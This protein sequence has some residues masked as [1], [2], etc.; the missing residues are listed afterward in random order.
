MSEHKAMGLPGLLRADLEAERAALFNAFREGGADA[1]LV[2]DT[3]IK[4]CSIDVDAADADRILDINPDTLVTLALRHGDASLLDVLLVH[5]TL[6]KSIDQHSAGAALLSEAVR[7]GASRPLLL[8][9]W[10]LCQSAGGQD[11][12]GRSPLGWALDRAVADGNLS[13]ARFLLERGADPDEPAVHEM[14]ARDLARTASG[15]GAES[16]RQLLESPLGLLSAAHNERALEFDQDLVEALAAGNIA[17]AHEAAAKGG[18]LRWGAWG[19]AQEPAAFEAGDA[20]AEAREILRRALATGSVEIAR[21]F[22]LESPMRRSELFFEALMSKCHEPAVFELAAA[23]MR[24]SGFASPSGSTLLHEAVQRKRMP[25]IEALLRRGADPYAQDDFGQTPA[26][27]AR[28]GADRRVMAVLGMNGPDDSADDIESGRFAGLEDDGTV[29]VVVFGPQS[30]GAFERRLASVDAEK[31]RVCERTLARMKQNDGERFGAPPPRTEAIKSLAND[32]PTFGEMIDMIAARA[33]TT[34]KAA[35]K[36]GQPRCF[37]LP[38][39]LLVG[40][41]GMGKTHVLKQLADVLETSFHMIQMGATSAGFVLAGMDSGWGGAKPGKIFEVLADGPY[42]NPIIA[43]DEID[44]ISRDDRY[45]VS[46]PLF[47]LLERGSAKEWSDEFVDAPM[48]ASHINFVATANSTELMDPAILSRFDVFHIPEPDDEEA[49]RIARSVYRAVLAREGWG[50]LFDPELEDA[51]LARLAS[52]TPR[53]AHL[54]LGQALPRACSKGR[55][56]LVVAD[57]KDAP[58]PKQR[59]GF[60]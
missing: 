8:K 43:L 58:A 28:E 39:I 49:R 9:T 59:M 44:K 34:T 40:P 47:S 30:I 36:A 5:S 41:P 55:D 17:Q 48:D 56:H 2:A 24:E 46:G 42:A 54:M 4:A 10:R 11:G 14:S 27:L 6:Y 57:F 21:F 53:E 37:K 1:A 29:P 26:E 20:A 50:D 31:K 7:R 22:L 23:G 16:A 18:V 60:N 51:V 52:A 15:P 12:E 32:F 35:Q 25:A 19:V 13:T 3:L 33:I 45:P 38:N